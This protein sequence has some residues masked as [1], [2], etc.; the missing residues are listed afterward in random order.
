MMA[1]A[2]GNR[3]S[4]MTCYLEARDFLLDCPENLPIVM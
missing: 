3:T 2:N 1:G 4:H